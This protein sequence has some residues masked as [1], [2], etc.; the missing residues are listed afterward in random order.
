MFPMMRASLVA[1]AL[2]IGGC[3]AATSTTPP[4]PSATV[5]STPAPTP[6]GSEP[7]TQ[8]PSPTPDV[9]PTPGGTTYD[10]MVGTWA[11]DVFETVGE[12]YTWA[13]TITLRECAEGDTCGDLDLVAQ[14]SKTGLRVRCHYTL[15]DPTYREDWGV[16]TLAERLVPADSDD[17]CSPALTLALSLA[18]SFATLTVEE[19]VD[20]QWVTYGVLRNPPA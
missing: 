19:W 13:T 1:A 6:G 15:A 14:D 10:D 5:V 3:G 4:P 17:Y 20:R 16:I 2:V 12:H 18:P 8:A 7:A 9:A 11:G